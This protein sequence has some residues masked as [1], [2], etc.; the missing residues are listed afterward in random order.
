MVAALT[1]GALHDLSITCTCVGTLPT[2]PAFALPLEGQLVCEEG[3]CQAPAE[4]S[5]FSFP[6]SLH[7]PDHMARVAWRLADTI[8]PL[9]PTF[10]ILLVELGVNII[11]N[12]VLDVRI[13]HWRGVTDTGLGNNDSIACVPLL[14]EDGVQVSRRSVCCRRSPHRRPSTAVQPLGGVLSLG[15]GV[16]SVTEGVLSGAAAG[17]S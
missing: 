16:W 11:L 8:P 5:A 17:T 15:V 6:F 14:A 13:F 1:D 7:A 10:V 3:P 2:G 9:P 12:H 4:E